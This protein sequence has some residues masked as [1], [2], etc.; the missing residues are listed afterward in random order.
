MLTEAAGKLEQNV[1]LHINELYEATTFH[2]KLVEQMYEV[3]REIIEGQPNCDPHSRDISAGLRNL[4]KN[5][6]EENLETVERLKKLEDK[7]NELRDK[8]DKALA[9]IFA[10][11]RKVRDVDFVFPLKIVLPLHSTN[12]C[13]FLLPRSRIIQS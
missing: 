4:I 5:L 11:Q 9:K 10:Q 3:Q 13:S 7:Y 2:M 8:G 12:D 1:L 6:L